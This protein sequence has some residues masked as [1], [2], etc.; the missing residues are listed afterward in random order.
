MKS[1]VVA[2]LLLAGIG[3]GLGL[4]A[5]GCAAPDGKELELKPEREY[6]TGSNLPTKDRKDDGGVKK[7]DPASLPSTGPGMP[8][9]KGG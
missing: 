5:V 3:L 8:S 6:R 4:G 9:G 1:C 2:C 7:V